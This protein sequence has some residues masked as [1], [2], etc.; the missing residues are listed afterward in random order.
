VFDPAMLDTPV[1]D[2]VFRAHQ[3]EAEYQPMGCEAGQAPICCWQNAGQSTRPGRSASN[4]H[5]PVAHIVQLRPSELCAAL[6]RV[7]AGQ[8][9]AWW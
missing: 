8:R 6:P 1:M 4:E 2:E 5:G 7:N 3:G 9:G